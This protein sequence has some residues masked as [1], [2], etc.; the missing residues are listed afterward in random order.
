MEPLGSGLAKCPTR[1]TLASRKLAT[2]A[3]AL[4]HSPWGV[5]RRVVWRTP[6]LQKTMRPMR[7]PTRP[8]GG[9]L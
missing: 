2:G 6:G 8:E 1:V 9:V 3:N 4:G 7:I 5:A